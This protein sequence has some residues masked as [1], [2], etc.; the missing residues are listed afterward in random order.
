MRVH[1]LHVGLLVAGV[2]AIGFM[3]IGCEGPE[4]PQG[5]AGPPGGPGDGQ[6]YLGN[7][8][9]SCGHCHAATTEAWEGTGHSEAYFALTGD[10]AT[11]LYCLQCHT[12][13]FDDRYDHDGNLISQGL[14]RDGFD[15]NPRDAV[16]N[17]HCEACHGPMGPALTHAPEIHKGLTGETCGS[18]HPAYAEYITSRHGTAIERAGGHEEWW[19]EFGRNPCWSCHVSEKFIANN[20]PD[21]AGHTPTA[22]SWQVTCVTCHDPHQ[23]GNPGQLRNV[24]SVVSPYGGGDNGTTSYTISGW[25]NGQL[26]VQCHHARRDSANIA[27]QIARGSDHPGP[28]PSSQGDMVAGRACYEIPGQNYAD[29]R[30]T[31]LHTTGILADM[32]VECHIVTRGFGDPGGPAYGHTFAP[33]LSKCQTCH[34]GATSFDVNGIQTQVANLMEQL[35]TLLPQENGEVRAAMD[36]V[37]WTLAQRQAG[38]AYFFVHDDKSH[39]VHNRDYTIRILTNAINH[40]SAAMTEERQTGARG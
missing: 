22:E 12:T 31:M 1:H 25:G 38:Y 16:K 19:A 32:C 8:A 5:P 39:G 37:N 17:V 36:T 10:N 15:D 24:G 2:L 11:D 4:G 26:C 9:E 14:D 40:L 27:G 18:C 35:S 33:Q 21:W 29:V 3:M 7:S 6:V 30:G 13:G 23:A 28:H 34:S 20:D